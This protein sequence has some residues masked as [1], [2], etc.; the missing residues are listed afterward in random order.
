MNART[1]LPAVSDAG[2]A[3]SHAVL[4]RLM[5][6]WRG[7]LRTWRS[8]HRLMLTAR[9]HAPGQ[10]HVLEAAIQAFAD[11]AA[12]NEGAAVDLAL[13]S[14][15]L[16]MS[17]GEPGAIADD[18]ALREQARSRWAHYLDLQAEHIDADWCV[19]T[20]LDGGRSPVALAC[21]VPRGLMQGLQQVA[22][23]HGLKLLAL[24][25][26]WAEALQQA[27][28]DLPPS[29]T[30]TDGEVRGWAWRE[31]AWQTQA[32][33]TIESGEWVL[34]TLAFVVADP[35]DACVD[36][37]AIDG[38]SSSSCDLVSLA[39]VGAGFAAGGA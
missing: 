32:E 6:R 3:P 31:G 33:A 7:R 5:A 4:S 26:W 11:W 18:Q 12:C 24:R 25:P 14:H 22:R 35:T 34:R 39:D 38:M 16:L 29:A 1:E 9:P 28:S 8:P 30:L 15:F 19:Q 10:A 2:V 37:P 13:S 21:A 20:S 36:A 23:Q 27:W 17:V